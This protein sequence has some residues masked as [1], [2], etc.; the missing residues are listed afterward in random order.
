[1][2]P[3][4]QNDA[5]DIADTGAVHHDLAGGN[6]PSQLAGLGGALDDLADVRND[7]PLRGHPHLLGQLGVL[8]QVPLLAVH[9]DKVLGLAQGMDDLQLLLA[10]VPGDVQPFQLVVDHVGALAVELVDDPGRWISHCRGWP[11][12]R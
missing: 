8:L 6:R 5:A 11:T 7:D 4:P 2:L 9:G 12:R 10:G 3:V 1:M